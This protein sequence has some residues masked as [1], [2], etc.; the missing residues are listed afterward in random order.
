MEQKSMENKIYK[1]SS[2]IL[3]DTKMKEINLTH[4]RSKKHEV[5]WKKQVV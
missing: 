2:D 4:Y 1:I 3:V 5:V